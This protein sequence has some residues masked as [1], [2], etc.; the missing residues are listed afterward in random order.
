MLP[1]KREFHVPFI[2]A[3]WTGIS[4]HALW[5]GLSMP[6]PW[7]VGRDLRDPIYLDHTVPVYSAS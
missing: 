2:E 4:I 3:G 5:E 7:R 6:Q 1:C